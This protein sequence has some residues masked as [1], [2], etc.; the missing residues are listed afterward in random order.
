MN[1]KERSK[2]KVLQNIKE[3][4]SFF[5]VPKLL[6]INAIL[7]KEGKVSVTDEILS[8]SKVSFLVVRSS[9][10]DEDGGLNSCAGEYDSILNISP[11]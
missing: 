2:A 8:L 5:N 10:A 3:R 6:S 1:S 11:I 9:A 7:Y 4:L